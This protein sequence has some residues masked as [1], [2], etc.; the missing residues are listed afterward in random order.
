MLE[1]HLLCHL[2][3]LSR[4]DASHQSEAKALIAV[5]DFGKAGKFTIF[6]ASWGHFLTQIPQ[7]MQSSSEISAFELFLST[8]TQSF[9]ILTTGQLNLH[10]NLHLLGLHLSRETTAILDLVLIILI[11]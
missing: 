2:A 5:H 11:W 8:F 1:S 3:S 4:K 7:P 10:S 6:M 9:P